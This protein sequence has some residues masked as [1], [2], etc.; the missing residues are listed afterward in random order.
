MEILRNQTA[1]RLLHKRNVDCHTPTTANGQLL[2]KTI[3]HHIGAFA[4]D[5]FFLAS[6]ARYAPLYTGWPV[7]REQADALYKAIDGSSWSL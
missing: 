4:L 3:N 2:Q 5:T 6:F 1:E 7:P